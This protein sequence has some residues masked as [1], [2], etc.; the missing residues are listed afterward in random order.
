[1]E[2]SLDYFS[3]D[4]SYEENE[5]AFVQLRREMLGE[6]ES[7]LGSEDDDAGEESHEEQ[8]GGGEPGFGGGGVISDMT[9]QDLVNLRRTIYLTVM[10]SAAVD[11]CAHKLMRLKLRPGQ[12]G[13]VATMIIE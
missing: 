7:E 6:S 8:A 13:E 10:S 4:P 9:E 2:E 12:E 3:F 5:K 11:E 1:M